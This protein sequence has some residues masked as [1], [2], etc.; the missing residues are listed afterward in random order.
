MTPCHNYPI[1]SKVQTQCDT[2]VQSNFSCQLDCSRN[3]SQCPDMAGKRLQQMH[4]SIL[5][6]QEI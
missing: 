6:F 3:L 2:R 5:I 4:N 1:S